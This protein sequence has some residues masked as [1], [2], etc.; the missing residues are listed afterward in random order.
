MKI[1]LAKTTGKITDK[2]FSATKTAP[3]KTKHGI[4]SV[5]EQFQAGFN[6]G[7]NSPS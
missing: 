2:L 3:T 5:K 7:T 4:I 1:N 6:Q